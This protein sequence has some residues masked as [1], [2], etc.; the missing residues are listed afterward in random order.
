MGAQ[1]YLRAGHPAKRQRSDRTAFEP[2]LR[3]PAWK[4]SHA[5][6]ALGKEFDFTELAAVNLR[7]KT[8]CSTPWTKPARLSW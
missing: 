5:A 4:F 2:P 1:R 6:A 3:I 7:A 8:S